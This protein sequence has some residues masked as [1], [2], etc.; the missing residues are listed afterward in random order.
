VRGR[1]LLIRAAAAMLFATNER[2]VRLPPCAGN[3]IAVP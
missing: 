3:P 2:A 1:S